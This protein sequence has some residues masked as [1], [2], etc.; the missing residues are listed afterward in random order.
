MSRLFLRTLAATAARPVQRRA[1]AALVGGALT[2]YAIESDVLADAKSVMAGLRVDALERYT[3]QLDA[4]KPVVADDP[5]MVVDRATG[6]A[7]AIELRPASAPAL[8]L[9]GVGVRTVSFLYMKVYSAGFY[10]DDYTLKRLPSLPGWKGYT[11]AELQGPEAETLIQSM[12]DA[13]AAVAVNVIP[14]RN[15]DFA[16]LRDGL[17]RTLVG[18]M[19]MG[20][21]RGE[22]TPEDDARL[23]DAMQEFKAVFPGG[24]V[25]KGNSLTLVRAADGNLSVEYQ[26]RVLGKVANQ[27]IANNLIMAYFNTAAPISPPLRDSVAEGLA[28]YA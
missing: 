3:V 20:R 11:P 24:S 15:T 12:L 4:A 1:A 27:W 18:R 8:A 17:T 9:V 6:V 26:G 28:K 7:H 10:V 16:H 2:L 14:V 22:I 19:K 5:N 23:T 25:P 21:H 13:P